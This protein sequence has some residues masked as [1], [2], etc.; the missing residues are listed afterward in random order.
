MS[1]NG[2]LNNIARII[3][4]KDGGH[5]LVFGR[6]TDKDKKPIGDNPFPLTVNEGDI[7]QM[8]AKSEDLQKLVD[9]GKMSQETA[10]KICQTVRFE[11]SR[12]PS[13]NQGSSDDDG[14]NF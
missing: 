9:D 10:D 13:S 14:V 11:I 4:K 5:F 3:K 2:W 6:R 1:K 7:F 12:G 8:K